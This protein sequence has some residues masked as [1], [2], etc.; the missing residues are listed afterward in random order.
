MTIKYALLF[1]LSTLPLTA[2]EASTQRVYY[3]PFVV[4]FHGNVTSEIRYGPPNYGETPE[5]DSKEF[6]PVLHLNNPVDVIGTDTHLDPDS[7]TQLGITD[8][9]LVPEKT[10]L[11]TEG[12]K[13]VVG[14]LMRASTGH[15]YTP[16]ALNVTSLSTSSDCTH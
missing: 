11:I 4:R 10:L 2:C 16:V 9:Q 5:R 12:C 6:V 13:L 3:E 8:I 7:E 1:A 14:T 15:H